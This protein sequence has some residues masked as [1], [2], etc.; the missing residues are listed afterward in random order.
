MAHSRIFQ[1]VIAVNLI[2]LL[3]G[4]ALIPASSPGQRYE[5]AGDE[6]PIAEYQHNHE[7]AGSENKPGKIDEFRESSDDHLANYDPAGDIARWIIADG[8]SVWDAEELE[9][10][11]RALGDTLDALALVGIDGH[12]LLE[13]YKFRRY[14]G[15]FVRDDRGLVAVV[16]HEEKVIT[17]SD[18][19]FKRQHGFSIYHEIGHA[20][21]SQLDRN[22][23]LRFHELA[24]LNSS[25]GGSMAVTQDGYW[26]RPIAHKDMEEATADAFALWVTVDNS[27]MKEPIFAGTPLDVQYESISQAVEDAL[28]LSGDI[29]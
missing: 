1:I 16:N 2:L 9:M 3:A 27:G 6:A 12:E 20:V 24:G 11:G 8:E 25:Q 23:S 10:T 26:M 7:T 18:A 14:A 17:L 5:V 13:G 15:E 21:D 4:P 22:L 19:A 29:K 28:I